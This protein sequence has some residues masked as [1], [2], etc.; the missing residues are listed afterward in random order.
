MDLQC[1]SNVPALTD[2]MLARGEG[3]KWKTG[4]C[5]GGSWKRH[6]I[7]AELELNTDNPLGT[8]GVL[9]NAYANLMRVMWSGTETCTVP[10]QF[11]MAVAQLNSEFGER[12]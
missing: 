5:Q 3:G 4:K 1:L 8:G 2:Y 7:C 12:V 6:I 9:A 11:K 10:R